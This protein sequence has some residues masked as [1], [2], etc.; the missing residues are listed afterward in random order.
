MEADLV[1]HCGG[2]MTGV[3]LNTFV[4]TDIPSGWTEFLPLLY[5]SEKNVLE[6]LDTVL[7]I[8]FPT[9]YE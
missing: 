7:K 2:S 8:I 4:L 9:P 3:F 6:A 1:A 5:R